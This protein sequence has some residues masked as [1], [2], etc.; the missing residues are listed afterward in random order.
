MFDGYGNGPS[1]KDETHKRR[2]GSEMGANVDL[3][4]DMMLPMKKKSFLANPNNKQRFI[5]LLASVM[6]KE[7]GIAV[8]HSPADADYD[9]AMSA[10]TIARSQPVVVVGDDT[11][12]L[13]LL[14][15]HFSSS[16]HQ[17]IY[18]Q[19]STNILDPAEYA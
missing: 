16:H 1:N 5:N 14:L 13:I 4:P 17:T 6:E 19:T 10:C 7:D 2:S 18:L 11:D 8:K 15:H 3:T 9:I 12:L